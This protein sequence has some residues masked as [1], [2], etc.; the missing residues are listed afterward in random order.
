MCF[1]PIRRIGFRVSLLSSLLVLLSSQAF[2]QVLSTNFNSNMGSW[3]VSPTGSATWAR[4]TSQ[5]MSNSGCLRSGE[6]CT[7]GLELDGCENETDYFAASPGISL[8]AGNIYQVSLKCSVATGSTRKPIIGIHTS[9]QR[10]G[11]TVIQDF[12]TMPNNW[13]Y[14]TYTDTFRV[15]SSGTYFMVFWGEQ[16]ALHSSN[17]WMDDF[18]VTVI[19]SPPTASLTAPANNAVYNPGSSVS[20]SATATDA[21]SNVSKV[22]FYVNGSKVAEDLTSPYKVLYRPY[23]GGSLVITA[24]AI[25][26]YGASHTSASRSII[27]KS[28]PVVTLTNP[29]ESS[30]Y[31]EG[32]LTF[33]ATA[34]DAD[35]SIAKVS[36]YLNG[37]T[38]PVNEDYSSPYS[39]TWTA[40]PGSHSLLVKATDNEGFTNEGFGIVQE[41]SFFTVI[42]N[43]C[44]L[45]LPRTTRQ[46]VC[47]GQTVELKSLPATIFATTLQWQK[48]NEDNQWE[49]ISGA[50]NISYMAANSGK[51]RARWTFTNGA[52]CE[53][54][55]DTVVVSHPVVMADTV[56][57]YN[58]Q[59][60]LAVAHASGGTAPYSYAWSALDTCLSVGC[61]SVRV[62]DFSQPVVVTVTDGMGCVAADTAVIDSIEIT[63]PLIHVVNRTEHSIELS[64]SGGKGDGYFVVASEAL[65]Y[66]SLIPNP[67]ILYIGDSVLADSGQVG[68]GQVVLLHNGQNQTVKIQNLLKSQSYQFHAYSFKR[69]YSGE[70]VLYSHDYTLG[71]VS[72]SGLPTDSEFMRYI[73]NTYADSLHKQDSIVNKYI[74]EHFTGQGGVA[75]NDITEYTIPVVFH[76]FGSEQPNASPPVHIVLNEVNE[77]RVLSQLN[78]L[79]DLFGND[80]GSTFSPK[81][82]RTGIRFCLAQI[83]PSGEQWGTLVDGS[84]LPGVKT[85]D[86]SAAIYNKFNLLDPY[87]LGI[88]A[89]YRAD[90]YLN[91]FVANGTA[92]R[93]GSGNTGVAEPGV[94]ILSRMNFCGSLRPSHLGGCPPPPGLDANGEYGHNIA[95]EVG[96]ILGLSHPQWENGQS[97]QTIDADCATVSDQI[98]NTPF[99]EYIN[100]LKFTGILGQ[101]YPEADPGD[102]PLIDNSIDVIIPN[103][104]YTPTPIC[105]YRYCDGLLHP[106]IVHQTVM[107]YTGSECAIGFT[108]ATDNTNQASEPFNQVFR[109]QSTIINNGR[110]SQL[111]SYNNLLSALGVSN[112]CLPVDGTPTAA[113]ESSRHISLCK[114]GG[115]D[116]QITIS[117]V[118]VPMEL[119]PVFVFE[120]L[121]VDGTVALTST[122]YGTPAN[123]TWTISS[124]APTDLGLGT[125]GLRVTL[126]YQMLSG[127][128]GSHVLNVPDFCR[129]K[130]CNLNSTLS[131]RW[132]FEGGGLGFNSSIEPEDFQFP[133][134][135]GSRRSFIYDEGNV[136]KFMASDARIVCFNGSAQ[137][138]Y[139]LN[140]STSTISTSYPNFMRMGKD[141]DGLFYLVNFYFTGTTDEVSGGYQTFAI[142]P[143]SSNNILVT[144]L[145]NAGLGSAKVKDAEIITTCDGRLLVVYIRAGK[146]CVSDLDISTGVVNFG[147]PASSMNLPTGAVRFTIS[148]DYTK[149]IT[150]KFDY[151]H[152]DVGNGTLPPNLYLIHTL[153]A[154]GGSTSCPYFS[155]RGQHIYYLRKEA[156]NA[157]YLDRARID[158]YG[159]VKDRKSQFLAATEISLFNVS[160]A[161]GPDM[162]IYFPNLSELIT[163]ESATRSLHAI[164]NTEPVLESDDI[165]LNMPAF[166]LSPIYYCPL[167]FVNEPVF[168]RPSIPNDY[169]IAVGTG[170][171]SQVSVQAFSTVCPKYAKFN[172]NDPPSTTPPG[173]N[174]RTHIYSCTDQ[175]CNFEIQAY[176]HS[177]EVASLDLT[178]GPIVAPSITGSLTP[179]CGVETTYG[180]SAVNPDYTYQFE[181]GNSGFG[182]PPWIG[183]PMVPGT[184]SIV[185]TPTVDITLRLVVTN[186]LTGCSTII[187]PVQITVSPIPPP[188]LVQN[189]P[190][191]LCSG[192]LLEVEAS[193]VSGAVLSWSILSKS[194][195]AGASPCSNCNSIAQTLSVGDVEYE[196]GT[197]TYQVTSTLPGCSTATVN[198]PVRVLPPITSYRGGVKDV[199]VCNG[200][201]FTYPFPN[202]SGVNYTWDHYV[203]S[204]SI[205][206]MSSCSTSCGTNIEQTLTTTNPY[207]LTGASFG[208]YHVIQSSLSATCEDD[209]NVELVYPT[210]HIS[211]LCAEGEHPVIKAV[212]NNPAYDMKYTWYKAPANPIGPHD[213]LPFHTG[214]SL[215][216]W[217]DAPLGLTNELF[218]EGESVGCKTDQYRFYV[219]DSSPTGT[220]TVQ[221]KNIYVGKDDLTLNTSTFNQSTIRMMGKA[222]YTQTVPIG[223]ISPVALTIGDGET[224]TFTECVLTSGCQNMWSGITTSFAS[225][226]LMDGGTVLEDAEKGIYSSPAAAGSD[227]IELDGCTLRNCLTGV[228]L[229]DFVSSN[230]THS[231][232]YMRNS[233]I[234]SDYAT[235]KEPYSWSRNK[236]LIINGVING[237]FIT[238]TGIY[239]GLNQGVTPEGLTGNTFENCH[240]GVFFDKR[241]QIVQDLIGNAFR[242]CAWRGISSPGYNA[243]FLRN[244]FETT[245]RSMSTTWQGQSLRGLTYNSTLDYIPNFGISVDMGIGTDPTLN[246]SGNTFKD[247]G[248]G[249][250][251]EASSSAILDFTLKCN[252]FEQTTAIPSGQERFGL[253]IGQ[254]VSLPGNRIG[255]DAEPGHA[256]PNSNYWPR[257]GTGLSPGDFDRYT[258]ILNESANLITYWGYGNEHVGKVEPPDDVAN[259]LGTRASFTQNTY[260]VTDGSITQWCTSH[261]SDPDCDYSTIAECEQDLM[262]NTPGCTGTITFIKACNE[263]GAFDNVTFPVLRPAPKDT[264]HQALVAVQEQIHGKQPYLGPSI[265]NPAYQKITIPI[266]LPVAIAEAE[267]EFTEVATGRVV[268]KLVLPR[269]GVLMPEIDVHLWGA[270]VYSYRLIMNTTENPPPTQKLVVVH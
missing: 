124:L 113:L 43:S 246:I 94:G 30:T 60:A 127:V 116:F 212:P 270:G 85:Y 159:Y 41:G 216:I 144:Q 256:P 141:A 8:T 20:I 86:V 101:G 112:P 2:A 194:N 218:V 100:T 221:G 222:S 37:S 51:Y 56:F 68:I 140:Q 104:R 191:D 138:L 164:S 211:G 158:S 55:V 196:V 82:R 15:A 172:F 245:D 72:T 261:H 195:V 132:L 128:I 61:D 219:I 170:C 208:S 229:S 263:G 25:D 156:G 76:F 150:D 59:P 67:D 27:V 197:I 232:F 58:G 198:L 87:T 236:N 178:H 254:G 45:T 262:N 64:F 42:A 193:S 260:T 174:T 231:G 33:T 188:V 44:S 28:A 6:V 240:T 129:V 183:L 110:L 134:N 215:D 179:L 175:S 3:V 199:S 210:L 13:D 125:Y 46:S 168:T 133:I 92:S 190:E 32:P 10:S 114:N 181:T 143:Q 146:L 47:A 213:G 108:D 118:S 1:F 192:T 242:N 154:P 139:L 147:S 84:I 48:K 239:S 225:S 65:G 220:E 171:E 255:F 54:V 123:N 201:E 214:T 258:S 69:G 265:P 148:S 115:V 161:T 235:M 167:D 177:T 160:M 224:V 207:L 182:S 253:K 12:G 202:I 136:A 77:C 62:S 153:A 135:T 4:I 209:I 75:V 142:N 35:G 29:V 52:T 186:K 234:T 93:Y 16:V 205:S 71:L 31:P 259:N 185:L 247:M 228:K 233:L 109:M 257:E 151:Y 105:G 162:R 18:S 96:H 99:N 204:G 11:A 268:H 79:N 149:I 241:P 119:T 145:H 103:S 97:C 39:Y 169:I 137:N 5:G 227:N 122:T 91:I 163:N 89:K 180:I 80:P 107:D 189:P 74:I 22:E 226:L 66:C 70:I 243:E 173:T 83:P 157:V 249:V 187:G 130:D 200:V 238:E 230:P 53:T 203:T 120:L 24:K 38:V 17:M 155:P 251:L 217:N 19:N 14:Y 73:H 184:N 9:Q 166:P 266:F 237:R 121:R 34:S 252:N 206:G 81:P 21:Q 50:T 111:V 267:L 250:S 223:T 88:E 264:S 98:C 57:T 78:A 90:K 131:S 95:H 40:T 36:F 244:I 23:S 117:M 26:S 126:S 49:N 102:D 63:P 269:N 7:E 165:Q 248:V 176:N 106:E 152:L